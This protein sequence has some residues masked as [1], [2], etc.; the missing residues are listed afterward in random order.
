MMA[1]ATQRPDILKTPS[2]AG[3]GHG[4]CDTCWYLTRQLSQICN[5]GFTDCIGHWGINIC[6]SRDETRRYSFSIRV[7]TDKWVAL[8]HSV[9]ELVMWDSR[10]SC[11]SPTVLQMWLAATFHDIKA[12]KWLSACLIMSRNAGLNVISTWSLLILLRAW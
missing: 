5:C 2:N 6:F 11:S 1:A 8:R 4:V 3:V 7:S 9:C 10:L 12:N